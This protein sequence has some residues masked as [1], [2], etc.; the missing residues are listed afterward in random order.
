[1]QKQLLKRC[2]TAAHVIAEGEGHASDVEKTVGLIAI[3]F[4]LLHLTQLL[5]FEDLDC[6]TGRL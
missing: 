1:M 5:N 3:D 2:Q 4:L 6:K